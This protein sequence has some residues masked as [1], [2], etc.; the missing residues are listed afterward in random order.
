[1]IQKVSAKHVKLPSSDYMKPSL[2]HPPT[3]YTAIPLLPLPPDSPRVLTFLPSGNTHTR[4]VTDVLTTV[5]NF[6]DRIVDMGDEH[7]N[8]G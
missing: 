6:I 4:P 1:M 5:V 7:L 3:L 8:Y 2:F